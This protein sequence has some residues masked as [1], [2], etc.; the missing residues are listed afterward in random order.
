M[1]V[2]DI[3]CLYYLL[4]HLH[5]GSKVW[6]FDENGDPVQ[7]AWDVKQQK[8]SQNSKKIF[9][10]VPNTFHNGLKYIRDFIKSETK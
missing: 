1:P 9:L 8:K 5:K 3:E 10:D 7:Q 2:H 6:T 4:A